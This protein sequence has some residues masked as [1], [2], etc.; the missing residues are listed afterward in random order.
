M[1]AKRSYPYLLI[2]LLLLILALSACQESITM[3]DETTPTAALSP[4]QPPQ[5]SPTT[6]AA[7]TPVKWEL[8]WSDEFEGEGLPDAEKWDYEEGFIR[9]NE[10][11]YYTRQRQENARLEGGNLVIEAR[12]EAFAE[13]QYTSASLVT[14]GKAEFTYGRIEVRAQLPTGTGTWPAIWMLGV[15]IDTVGWPACG[16]I[17]IM[18][19]VGF[20]PDRIHANI[21]TQAYNHVKK[22]NKGASLLAERPYEIF[23][24]YAVEWFP[25]HL[26]FYL[27]EQKYFTFRNE[28]TG[29]ETWPYDQP[30]YLILNLA[31]GGSWGGM[32]GIDEAIFPQRFVIDY[33][34]VYRAAP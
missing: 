6:I 28:N 1:A 14:R 29:P 21:H 5:S 20:D 34:R 18:E 27:D 10:A 16:E 11:Q 31:I 8:A 25:D 33:V 9:N 32:K 23:H 17:D 3:N 24:V 26:D 15:N 7:T 13:G 2:F 30:H 19:N 22:T 12:K 4:T